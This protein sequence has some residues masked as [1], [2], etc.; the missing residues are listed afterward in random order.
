[1]KPK[2]G[3]FSGSDLPVTV[4]VCASPMIRSVTA[5]PGV[6]MLNVALPRL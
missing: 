6:T 1:M 3:L 4:V 5:A 2:A